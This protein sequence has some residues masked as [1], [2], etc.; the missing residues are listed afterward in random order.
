LNLSI[1]RRNGSTNLSSSDKKSESSSIR[2]GVTFTI[3]S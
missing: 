2:R 1:L 3:G